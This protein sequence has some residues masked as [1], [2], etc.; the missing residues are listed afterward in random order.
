MMSFSC[1]TTDGRMAPPLRRGLMFATLATVAWIGWRD[2]PTPGVPR[3]LS[4]AP[5]QSTLVAAHEEAAIRRESWVNPEGHTPSAH[6]CST[7]ILPNGDAMA[8]W[9]G[10]TREGAADV[11]IFTAR[12]DG[13]LGEWSAPARVVDRVTA[14]AELGRPVRKVGNA[15]IFADQAGTVWLMYVTVT[16]GGWS[17]STLNVKTSRDAG[18]TW[19]GSERLTLNSFFNLSSLVRNKPVFADDGRIGLPIYHEMATTYAQMLWLT[20][21]ANGR[22]ADYAVRSLVGTKGVIQP[23]VVPGSGGRAIMVLRDH[24]PRRRLH[25]AHSMDNGW[26]WTTPVGGTLPNPDAATDALRLRDGRLL[27]VYNHATSGREN[28]RLAVSADE[29]RSWIPGPMI[30]DETGREFSYPCLSE[31]GHGRI[32]LTYTWRRQRIKHV[33]F[34]GA[35]L[36]QALMA[37]AGKP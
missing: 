20:P 9:F 27:L 18:R 5:V 8:V 29:G 10:G 26:T 19:S 12:Y 35:W 2:G 11:A 25:S 14:R 16:V 3:R 15:V 24:G 34:N 6:S 1:A 33:E 30:E 22:L 36:R 28:L 4:A 13:R 32:H 21:G 31:D 7:T 17:G 37:E 23:T